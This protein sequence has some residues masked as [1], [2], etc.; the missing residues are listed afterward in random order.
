MLQRIGPVLLALV[1]QQDDGFPILFRVIET[2]AESGFEAGMEKF[3]S[4]TQDWVSI[5][6]ERQ[7]NVKTK[8]PHPNI[9]F[10]RYAIVVVAMGRKNTEGYS[11]EITRIVKTKVDI[12]IYLKKKVPSEFPKPKAKVTSP[13]VLARIDKPDLP[14]VFLDEPKTK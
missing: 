2:H 6:T 14:V 10:D 11:V 8:T 9:D 12:R 13:F 1:A 3:I 7:R 5:W 4:S